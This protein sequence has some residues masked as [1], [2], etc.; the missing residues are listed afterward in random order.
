MANDKNFK[1]FKI[2]K[3]SLF[4]PITCCL[5]FLNVLC[6]KA[7]DY[8]YTS[9]GFRYVKHKHSESSYQHAW[10]KAHNGI[11]EYQNEDFTRVDCLTES[12]AVEF[13]FSNKWAESV[14]QALHYGLMT[15][16]RGMVV[17]I[18]ENPS[19]EFVYYSRVKRLAEIYDFDI[20][21]VTPE[22]LNIKN[23]KCPYA[24]CKCRK[25]KK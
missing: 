22:I 15:G 19:R 5:I 20:E 4:L 18:L 6:G 2:I 8:G 25:N 24:D 12:H 10:C 7:F 16:K 14:G 23:G 17:L 9:D 13:D 11:E 1:R 3:K 21:Y